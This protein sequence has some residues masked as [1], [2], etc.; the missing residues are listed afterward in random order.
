M[1]QDVLGN[2]L[3]QGLLG[4]LLVGALIVIFYLYKELKCAR[5]D[6]LMSMQEMWKDAM[7]YRA[8]L[9]SLI[10]NIL[11]ILRNVKRE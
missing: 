9:K 11:D 3:T 8:E 7:T 1:T 5:N 6:H 10:Q 2:I 4:V